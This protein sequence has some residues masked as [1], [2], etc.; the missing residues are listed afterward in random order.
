MVS[1]KVGLTTSLRSLVDS[2]NVN[3]QALGAVSDNI[4]NVNTIGYSRKEITQVTKISNGVV[5][6]V[7]SPE[8]RRAVDSFLV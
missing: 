7:S 5:L 2:L 8:V 3:Q 4:S 6:G 1:A